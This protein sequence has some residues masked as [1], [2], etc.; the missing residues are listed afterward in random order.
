MK[1]IIYDQNGSEKYFSTYY[2]LNNNFLSSTKNFNIENN[3][4]DCFYIKKLGSN[5]HPRIFVS[6][7]KNNEWIK[8]DVFIGDYYSLM[9]FIATNNSS[10]IC[11]R[12]FS[13]AVMGEFMSSL[14]KYK[15]MNI[16]PIRFANDVERAKYERHLAKKKEKIDK[17][18]QELEKKGEL[19]TAE[20]YM[21]TANS[22]FGEE[23][24]KSRQKVIKM[25]NK[26]LN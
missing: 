1:E 22:I 4:E 23:R 25:M 26:S 10:I 7:K 17:L 5:V 16:K 19:E 2:I 15:H 13:R 11:L 9:N 24:H 6:E 20:D 18:H 21:K 8:N 3:F 14:N 12:G